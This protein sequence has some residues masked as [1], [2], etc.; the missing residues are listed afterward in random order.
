MSLAMWIGVALFVL[1]YVI[2]STDLINKTVIALVG[3]AVFIF[4][5]LV[6]PENA[7]HYVDLNVIFLLVSMM[8][9]INITK[10]TGLFQWIA[11]KA[12]KAAKGEPILI[13]ILMALITCTLSAFLDNVTTVL[14]IMPVLLL[15]ATELGVSPIPF[16]IT[17]AIASNI[18]GTATLIGDPPNI[19]IGS[20]A[21]LDFMAF[22]VNL[23]PLV[24]ILM[25][26]M[27][28]MYYLMFRKQLV[29]SNERKAKIMDFDESKSI[30]DKGL[31]IKCLVVLGA[32][33]LGFFF[34]G[35][36]HIE[37]SLIALGG[38][39]VLMLL[40]GSHEIDDFIR[41]VEWGTI[42]FFVGLF[43][44]VGGLVDL[45]LMKVLATKILE[46]TK[47]NIM[48]TSMLLIWVSG[49]LSAVIDNIPYVATMIPLIQDMGNTL[50]QAQIEPLWWSLAIGACFGGNG[51][52]VGAS[53][54]VVSVG[55]ANKSGYKISFMDFTKIGAFV[56]VVT[57]V[58]STAY[59]YLRYFLF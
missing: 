56:T 24:L 51:T 43:I 17:G 31:M 48:T 25:V 45:G 59:V 4:A 5:G 16:V 28:F 52:L 34:H 58:I 53:A 33:V 6:K 54:N 57:L 13:L 19:M 44:L 38:A 35:L 39:S 41:D 27:S 32:V 26:V 22:V 40:A 55:L 23:A 47:G 50:G 49:F 1:V 3:A 2:I 42:F 11:I 9:I 30:T 14:I 21:K 7:L 18:G 20:A 29:V 46:L 8:V 37:A 12:A 15:I 36:L 10:K